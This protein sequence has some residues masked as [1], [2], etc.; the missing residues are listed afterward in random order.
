MPKNRPA[1]VGGGRL[2]VIVVGG[3]ID[4]DGDEDADGDDDAN[5]DVALFDVVATRLLLS[6][7]FGYEGEKN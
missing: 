4:E 5:G 7:E 6:V 2:A 3:V 1:N